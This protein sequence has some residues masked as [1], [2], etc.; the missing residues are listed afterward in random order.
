ME[1]INM[2]IS[3]PCWEILFHWV[4]GVGE[5]VLLQLFQESEP[6]GSDPERQSEALA[7]LALYF[8]VT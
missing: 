7:F 2:Q 5:S 4:L 1:L 3:G 6:F 8:S